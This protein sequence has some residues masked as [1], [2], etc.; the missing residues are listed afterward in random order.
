MS[1]VPAFPLGTAFLP[2]EAVVLRVFESRYLDLVRD[3]VER[4]DFFVTALISAGSEVG[5]G[6][7]RFNVGVGVEIDHIEPSDIGLMLYGHATEPLNI[8]EWNDDYSYPRAECLPQQLCNQ[9]SN[10][11]DAECS[12]LRDLTNELEKFFDFLATFDIPLPAPHGFVTSLLP[13]DLHQ[14]S[15]RDCI[16]IFW[17]CAR[18]LPSTP[19]TRSELLIDQT[20]LQRIERAIEEIQHLTDI[21]RFRYGN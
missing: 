20:L 9:E 18:L 3:V 11:T 6:D 15:I 21:V 12:R 5:G 4:R 19:L 13:S 16:Q 7:Q 2:G 17:S 1:Y 8:T 14:L 10:A